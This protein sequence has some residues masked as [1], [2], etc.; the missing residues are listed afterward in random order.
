[1]ALK[2]NVNFIVFQNIAIEKFLLMNLE[3][4]TSSYKDNIV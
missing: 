1:M 4:L 2:G 3:I